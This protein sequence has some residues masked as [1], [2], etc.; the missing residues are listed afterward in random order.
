[1]F[2]A[3][4]QHVHRTPKYSSV[5][6]QNQM[7]E[8]FNANAGIITNAIEKYKTPEFTQVY[9]SLAQNIKSMSDLISRFYGQANDI[10]YNLS[11]IYNIPLLFE[12]IEKDN[13]KELRAYWYEM[14]DKL[15]V[16]LYS[17]C[18]WNLREFYYKKV[19]LMESIAKAVQKK[20]KNEAYG[21]Y[22]AL[23]QT[24]IALS[25]VITSCIIKNNPKLF[26]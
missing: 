21:Y 16:L 18:D 1:M 12:I 13:K 3:Y 14:I 6:F 5:G 22:Q 7:I 20:N 2:R 9:A 23:A 19:A 24:N 4:T 26:A 8:I 17:F 15:M 11:N 10:H 25:Q